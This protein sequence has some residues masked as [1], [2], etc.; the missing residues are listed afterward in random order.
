MWNVLVWSEIII[1]LVVIFSA[2]FQ[3][4][5]STPIATY[6]GNREALKPKGKE[7]ILNNLTKIFGTLLFINAILLLKVQQ[8][9]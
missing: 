3:E 5:K 1:A 4:S 6:A 9:G 8:I 2:L 7:A